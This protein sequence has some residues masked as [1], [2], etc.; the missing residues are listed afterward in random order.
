M[1]KNLWKVGCVMLV[2][3]VGALM[4]A[5]EERVSLVPVAVSNAIAKMFPGA[6]I[7]GV[8]METEGIE[9]Y[10]A[11]VEGEDLEG[12]VTVTPEGVVIEKEMEVDFDTLP[13]EV[14]AALINLADTDNIKEVKEETVYYEVV[15]KKLERPKV[16]Y[17]AE[18]VLDGRE[19]IVELNAKGKIL[20]KNVEQDNDEDQGQSGSDH[21]DQDEGDNE[22]HEG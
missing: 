8:A 4:Y 17:E 9:V 10:E 19:V 21:D 15:L 3:L 13:K 11:E 6:A 12:E 5:G 1:K 18:V 14:K 2:C 20:A 7:E 16:G 22:D